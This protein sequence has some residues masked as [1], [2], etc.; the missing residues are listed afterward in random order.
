MESG[1]ETT[2]PAG[3]VDHLAS[4]MRRLTALLD[5]TAG[6]Y[7]E[8]L[9]RDPDGMRACLDGTA[10]PPW[11]V[12]HSL[13]QDFA[14]LHGPEA[15]DRETA[16]AAGL[17]AAAVEAHDRRPG[18]PAE[19][20]A[21]LAAA[22]TQQA[23]SEHARA[24]LAAELQEAADP[25]RAGLLTRELSWIHD[26]LSRAASRRT[27][28]TARLAAAAEAPGPAA[29]EAPAPAAGPAPAPAAG[30]RRTNGRRLLRAAV[31]GSGGA[32]FAGAPEP[33]TPHQAAP[34]PQLPETSAPAPRGA[35]YAPAEHPPE[36][37]G[38]HVRDRAAESVPEGVPAPGPHPAPPHPGPHPAPV[39][40]QGSRATAPGQPYAPPV[41]P[42]P[43]PA[44]PAP[45]GI[46]HVRAYAPG[47]TPGYTPAH[48]PVPAPDSAGPPAVPDPAALA[49]GL[50]ALRA[51]GRTGEAHVLL[52]EAAA[53]P[54]GVLPGLA[55]ELE[56]AGLA[57]DWA[58]LLWEAASL[59]PAQL[60]AAAAA[61]GAAGRD[62]DCGRLLRQ[63]VARPAAE[64][65][66]AALV[67]AEA[68]RDREAAA[69]LG[70]FVRVRSAEDS[71]R[72]ARQ[73]PPRLVHRLL[74]AA[75]AVSESR[76]RDLVHALRVTGVATGR[77]LA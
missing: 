8:F 62:D 20:A 53:W 63:G 39:T 5:P 45:D 36:P 72:L 33:G 27:D 21:Q 41:H 19:L 44:P 22:Q 70:A 3:P 42:G 7:A 18:A 68:G 57:A 56:R 54:P 9:G 55:G 40:P 58:T 17:R 47:H 50:I 51:Q 25:A 24:R 49:A 74:D 37:A 69:L 11:D 60:A 4:H 31:R 14:A 67:L 64:I 30:Q 32:R 43:D 6:W 75:R 28:L 15:A 29:A 52:C 71:A 2:G 59:P 1:A 46:A 23:G 65:A 12:L 77:N 35:R 38:E 13:L 16:A 48:D 73:D 34:L 10:I 26:D 76:H 61:L 66:D